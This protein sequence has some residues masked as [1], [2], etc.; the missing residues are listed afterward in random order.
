[1]RKR[2]IKIAIIGAGKI[3]NSLAPAL[4]K[5]GYKISQ[6][7][8]S[9]LAS[10]ENLAKKSKTKFYSNKFTNDLSSCNFFILSVPDLEISKIAKKL[11]G[12]KLDFN[13]SIFIHLSGAEN[14]K[15]L[16]SLRKRHAS[17]ASMHIMQTFPSKQFCPIKDSYA[18]IECESESA[19]IILEKIAADLSL[20]AFQIETKQKPLYHLAGVFA[21]NFLVGNLSA[22]EFLFDKSKKANLDFFSVLEPII[23]T[24]LKNISKNG[25]ANS[26]S[27]PV[28]RGDIK[29]VEKHI[30]YLK[31]LKQEELLLSYISQSLNLLSLIPKVQRSPKHQELKKILS[32][33]LKN[34]YKIVINE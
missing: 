34:T 22:S 33:E 4:M 27:G 17:V 13:N 9:N 19:R 3:A 25:T 12:L 30:L 5:S 28:Q 16:S 26:L 7:V 15:I 29:T 14:I 24:T 21:S 2:D 31:N 1:M 11:A 20:K 32:H 8:S 18:A 23:Q 6:I 10:A